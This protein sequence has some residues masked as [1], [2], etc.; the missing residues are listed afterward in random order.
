M[1]V[2]FLFAL[3]AGLSLQLSSFTA[4]AAGLDWKAG[5]ATADITPPKPVV[6]LGYDGRNG[7]FTEVVSPIYAKALAFEDATGHRAVIVT[8]DLVG[9]QGDVSEPM[10][11]RILEKAGL[12]RSQLMLNASHTHTAPLVSLQ[13]P[14]GGNFRA[15][16][17]PDDVKNTIEYTRMLHDKVV[18]VVA[19]SIAD[20]RPARLAWST[21]SVPFVMSRRLPVKDR[22]VMRA[23]PDAPV[24]HSVPVLRVTDADGKLRGVLFGCACHNVAQGPQNVIAGDYAGY[25]QALLEEKHPGTTAM[26]LMGCGADA[27]PEPYGKTEVAKKHGATLGEEVERVL[28]LSLAEVRGPLKTE[29]A[30]SQLPLKKLARDEIQKIADDKDDKQAYAESVMAW[31]MLAVLDRRQS[32]LSRYTAPFAV[33]QFDGDLTLVALPAEPVAEY[34]SL[35]QKALG[36]DKLW[37][38]GYNN[39]CFGYLPTDKVVREGGHEAI[40]VTLFSWDEKLFGNVGFFAPGVQDVV[41]GTVRDLAAKAGRKP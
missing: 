29:F 26:F 5:L 40:G 1:L 4:S 18:D 31:Q 37:V 38:A 8:A 9:F 3:C 21:G 6:L 22:V 2:R 17:A 24:D 19:R 20:L 7:P 23:N 35:I 10:V 12:E 15:G 25:A 13:P 14:T 33:W 34:V 36:A 41:L 32:L 11:K 28:G 27:N 16:M 30:R 39:D